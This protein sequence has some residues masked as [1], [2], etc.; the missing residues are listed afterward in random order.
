MNLASS[1]ATN[2]FSQWAMREMV[3]RGAREWHEHH[4][5]IKDLTWE[6]CSSTTIGGAINVMANGREMFGLTRL[7]RHPDWMGFC[8][9]LREINDAQALVM[10]SPRW[11]GKPGIVMTSINGHPQGPRLQQ[12]TLEFPPVRPPSCGTSS[13]GTE[14]GNASGRRLNG[15]SGDGGS[16][17][18]LPTSCEGPPQVIGQEHSQ[19]TP[20][21]DVPEELREL[22]QLQS[23][24]RP[25]TTGQSGKLEATAVGIPDPAHKG[26]QQRLRNH[27][28]TPQ[29]GLRIP[30]LCDNYPNTPRIWRL[31]GEIGR[32]ANYHLP[33]PQ[34]SLPVQ[35][36]P[37]P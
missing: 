15:D 30:G 18:G 4:G 8:F 13:S 11:R 33:L 23:R 21:T 27:P 25:G 28:V 9:N 16:Q 10:E 5:I 2:E 1:D 26:R 6:G 19:I 29:Q 3:E 35:S 31:S 22:P 36:P 24:Q 7:Q 17:A 32:N 37:L 34:Y 12:A 14:C 20:A